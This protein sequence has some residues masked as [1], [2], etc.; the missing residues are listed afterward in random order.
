MTTP[1]KYGNARLLA[2]LHRAIE[3]DRH[4]LVR[5]LAYDPVLLALATSVVACA[6]GSNPKPFTQAER[7]RRRERLAVAR[8]KRWPIEPPAPPAR[9][10]R[11]GRPP[12]GGSGAQGSKK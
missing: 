3:R 1:R 9:P 12:G 8:K 2:A 11:P 7:A 10:G 6:A 5:E 4:T